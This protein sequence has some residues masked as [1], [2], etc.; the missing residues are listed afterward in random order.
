MRRRVATL[1]SELIELIGYREYSA[2]FAGAEGFGIKERRIKL[3]ELRE[4]H[5]TGLSC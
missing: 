3:Q 4:E 5:S 2:R 1:I